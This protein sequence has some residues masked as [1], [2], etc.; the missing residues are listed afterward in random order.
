MQQTQGLLIPLAPHNYHGDRD[1][2]ADKTKLTSLLHVEARREVSEG[3]RWGAG[4]ARTPQG[5]RGRVTVAA[6]HPTNSSP[7]LRVDEH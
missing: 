2:A 1:W 4:G 6:T 3:P 5:V 7:V